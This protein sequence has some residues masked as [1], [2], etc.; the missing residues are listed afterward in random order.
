MNEYPGA[1]GYVWS[2]LAGDATL[3]GIVGDRI[4][5]EVAP[6]DA[7][8]PLV[9]FNLIAARDTTATG[10][11]RTLVRFLLQVEAIAEGR[12]FA[13]L[14]AA[15]DRIDARLVSSETST[16]VVDGVT[17]TVL[18]GHRERAR[19]WTELVD[20]RAFTH[21]GGDYALLLQP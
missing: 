2:R 9:V 1:A 8:Y 4:Y 11:H 19:A 13:G 7:V 14:R 10:A 3:A 20:G 21:L 5:A 17:Y 18:G 6:E 12:S 16:V 15:A